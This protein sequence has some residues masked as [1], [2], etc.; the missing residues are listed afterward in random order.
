MNRARS[1]RSCPRSGPLQVE[2][3]RMLL[4]S[5]VRFGGTFRVRAQRG[6]A[7]E[8]VVPEPER[9][10]QLV[11]PLE[12]LPRLDELA[13]L[14]LEGPAGLGDAGALDLGVVIERGQ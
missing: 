11:R 2:T 14:E 6:H 10:R 3:V 5:L 1:G 12:R 7:G 13:C 8:R 9:S 4:G